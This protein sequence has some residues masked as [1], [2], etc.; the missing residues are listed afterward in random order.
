MFIGSHFGTFLFDEEINQHIFSGKAL[1]SGSLNRPQNRDNKIPT[2]KFHK[3]KKLFEN[4][5]AMY[6]AV[7]TVLEKFN[8]V[9]QSSNSFTDSVNQFKTQKTAIDLLRGKAESGSK[10]VTE[11]KEKFHDKL[12][13]QTNSL[14]M[15]LMALFTKNSDSQSFHKV[16]IA[17]SDL[18]RFRENK[19]IAVAKNTLEMARANLRAMT[20]Y[21]VTEPILTE[22]ATNLAMFENL[23]TTPRTTIGVRKVALQEMSEL[24][25]KANQILIAQLDL[26]I[27]AYEKTNPDFYNEYMSARKVVQYGIRHEKGDNID[28]TKP[29]DTKPV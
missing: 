22:F 28:D 25:K 27:V 7:L 15:I 3:M 24:F 26:M 29:E 14:V 4:W 12:I 5:L 1:P 11:Q 9:W 16:K 18:E 23:S 2:N 20:D 21:Q 17:K 10:G 8:A 13:E 6:K 19:L